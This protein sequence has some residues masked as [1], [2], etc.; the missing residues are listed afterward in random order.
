MAAGVGRGEREREEEAGLD[1]GTEGSWIYP[2]WPGRAF[3]RVLLT[4]GVKP[5]KGARRSA[6]WLGGSRG[7]AVPR[8]EVTE[9][10]PG[11]PG[12]RWKE[13]REMKGRGGVVGDSRPL[14]A[15]R[16]E[17]G[18][19]L[20]EGEPRPRGQLSASAAWC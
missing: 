5:A 12:L 13:E 8:Q 17:G 15:S 14:E 7:P 19:Y 4:G 16:R 3:R 11:P 20:R 18:V 1:Q 6:D 10:A 9:A 2:K